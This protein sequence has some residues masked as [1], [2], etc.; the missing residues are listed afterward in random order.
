[1]QHLVSQAHVS[2]FYLEKSCISFKK[3][4]KKEKQYKD[5]MLLLWNKIHHKKRGFPVLYS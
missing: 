1:M 5:W 3:K 4:K 2:V